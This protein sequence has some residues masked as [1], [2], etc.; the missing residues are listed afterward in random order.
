[1]GAAL[2]SRGVDAAS[3]SNSRWARMLTVHPRPSMA[4]AVGQRLTIR[5]LLPPIGPCVSL[6]LIARLPLRRFGVREATPR[7]RVAVPPCFNFELLRGPARLLD[8]S[9]VAIS[10]S[11]AG[12]VVSVR[13][14]DLSI[15]AQRSIYRRSPGAL[16]A[17]VKDPHS[18]GSLF[19][20]RS[21]VRMA[22][23]NAAVTD[24]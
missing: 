19:D 14:L 18:L 21:I 5:L 13:R 22:S 15:C 11:L 1:M 9:F 3:R 20:W 6:G 8:L 24:L 16:M 2:A 17:A 12:W 4:A 10:D 7:C 23:L